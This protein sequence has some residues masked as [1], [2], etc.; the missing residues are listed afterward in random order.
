MARDTAN[1]VYPP[2]EYGLIIYDEGHVITAPIF[3]KAVDKFHHALQLAVTATSEYSETKTVA[4]HLP[5]L[6][7]RLPLAEAIN[8]GDLCNVRPAILKTNY[9]IDEDR[10]QNFVE[11]QQGR[12]LNEHQLQQLLNQ[13]ARNEAVV[14]TYLRG[15][16]PDSGA[17]YFGQNGMVFCTGIQHAEAMVRQF[18]RSVEQG[19]GLRLGEWLNEEGIELIAPVHGQTK[20]AWLKKGML[21]GARPETRQYQGIKEW[22]SEGEIFDLHDSGKIL[23]LA[24]VPDTVE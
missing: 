24:T 11:Q 22:Y 7:F 16:D 9:T 2:G 1:T 18:N 17:R 15:A 23:L 20:G 13:E 21:P 6:Y 4:Q 8:R 14:Q 5:H 10:F 19:E 3:G 12:P